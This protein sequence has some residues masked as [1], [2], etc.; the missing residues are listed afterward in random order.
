MQTHWHEM[1]AKMPWRLRADAQIEKS[2]SFASI[3]I[4]HPYNTA[5]EI[6]NA[7]LDA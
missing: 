4:L 1:S 5:P 6:W 7:V 2:R 3:T